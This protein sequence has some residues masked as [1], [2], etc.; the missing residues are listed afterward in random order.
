MKLRTLILPVLLVLFTGCLT[1][2]ENY[3]FKKNGSGSMEYVVDMSEI[4]ELMK[5]L[6]EMSEVE[7]GEEMPDDIG[8]LDMEDELKALKA[9][10]GIKKVK[11]DAKKKWVQRLKFNFA[12]IDA[13]NRALNVLMADSSGMQ[14]TFFT[15]DGSTL[16]R[17]NN[18]H[19]YELGAGMA[20]GGSGGE[21]QEGNDP[22]MTE[23]ADMEAF[24]GS[25]K[26]KYSFKFAEEIGGTETA[27]GINKETVGTKEIKFDTDWAVIS[28]NEKALDLRIKLDR[29]AK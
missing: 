25:M 27:E 10:P 17:T 14:H 19:A 18:R 16:V 24:L 12:D 26:Y 9:I 7:G 28:T 22:T 8:S 4:G 6:G 29:P 21:D 3:T 2:E 23:T 20:A 1:I 5:T 15:W 13:L 11:L